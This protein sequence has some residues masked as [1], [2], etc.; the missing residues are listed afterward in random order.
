MSV[1]VRQRLFV[2]VRLEEP[3]QSALQRTVEAVR[4]D[5]PGVRWSDPETWHV[6]L[7]FVGSVEEEEAQRVD[8]VTA[9]VA[10][11]TPALQLRLDSGVGTFNNTAIW[12]GIAYD[13][14]LTS[15]VEGLGRGLRAA[16]FAI[17]ERRFTPHCTFARLPRGSAMPP[18]L[19]EELRA[20]RVA[21]PVER[22][23][24]VR[25]RL[26]VG[27]AE[28]AVRSRHMLTGKLD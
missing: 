10:A 9:E 13:A 16:G 5:Y 11:A 7:G 27:G 18:G 23:V 26:R 8:A 19:L 6:T 28:H 14:D 24:V 25:S 15:A 1:V 20:P 12:A 3:A 22:F 21:W 4:D 17:E 2:A